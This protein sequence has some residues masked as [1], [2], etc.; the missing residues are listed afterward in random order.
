MS[1]DAPIAASGAPTAPTAEQWRMAFFAIEDHVLRIES[2]AKVANFLAGHLAD[3]ASADRK[4]FDLSTL[5][6][7]TTRSVFHLID[8]TEAADKAYFEAFNALVEQE[9]AALVAK[10]TRMTGGERNG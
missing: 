3:K 5:V 7:V 1:T 2:M 10:P 8:A 9:N 6:E 4:Q